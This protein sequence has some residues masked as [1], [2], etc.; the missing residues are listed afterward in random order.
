MT[1]VALEA[2]VKQT[3]EQILG[4]PQNELP[5]A[6]KPRSFIGVVEGKVVT[7]DKLKDLL[8][9]YSFPG[10]KGK[11]P[12]TFPLSLPVVAR[13]D[14]W[15]EK[16]E[17]DLPVVITVG[18]N[19][20]NDSEQNRAMAAAGVYGA[21]GIRTRLGDAFDLALSAIPSGHRHNLFPKP[22]QFHLVCVYLF[23]FLTN[24]QWDGMKLSPLDEGLILHGLGYP[25]PL[26]ALNTL[27][28]ALVEQNQPVDWVVFH[29]SSSPIPL[30]ASIY[31]QQRHETGADILL[32]DDLAGLKP[33]SNSVVFGR[34]VLQRHDI[35]G[36]NV[37]E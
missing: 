3:N 33:I 5:S 12:N 13:I 23:P 14:R 22:G 37:D 17:E 9:S 4:M 29:G 21:T 30:A 1:A 27:V 7:A 19:P 24:V 25:H 34:P 36:M 28:K 26:L 6:R 32:C 2:V 11:K 16:R 20:G 10:K 18:M 35:V 15:S 8:P 31:A